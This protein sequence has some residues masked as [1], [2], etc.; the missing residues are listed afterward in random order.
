MGADIETINGNETV[1]DLIEMVNRQ[2]NPSGVI[3]LISMTTGKLKPATYQCF[4][5][6]KIKGHKRL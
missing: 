1:E 4:A 3:T 2:E 5:K 6:A